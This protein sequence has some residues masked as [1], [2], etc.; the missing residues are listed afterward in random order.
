MSAALYEQMVGRGLRGPL[1]GGT[2]ACKVV[3]VQD[4][5]WRAELRAGDRTMDE[6]RRLRGA[7][8][9]VIRC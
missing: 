3:D 4:D 2:A 1:N 5:G 9:D 7:G 8:A 6:T